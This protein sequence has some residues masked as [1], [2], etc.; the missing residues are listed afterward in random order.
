MDPHALAQAYG[1][2][3]YVY[4]AAAI[5]RNYHALTGALSLVGRPVAIHYAVK[6][7]YNLAV[8]HHLK[9][10]GAGAD[11][12]SGGE[13][14][15]A[16]AAGMAPSDI[17]FSGVAKT[18]A[19][20]R[21]ALAVGVGQINLESAEELDHLIHLCDALGQG[22]QCAV[23]I[24]PDV[25]TDT[26]AKISTGRAD[27]KFGVDIVTARRMFERARGT[28]VQLVGL[29][30]HIGSQLLSLAPYDQA[31]GVMARTAQDFAAAGHDIQVCDLGG[32]IG[33][34]YRPHEEPLDLAS[35]AALI[36]KHSAGFPGRLAMEPGRFLVANAG[37]LLV[38]VI[39]IK[40]TAHK[41]F[42][43]VDG[44]MND[45]MRPALYDAYHAITP[46]GT[47]SN[48][49]MTA[50]VVGGVCESSDVF[51]QGALL[52]ANLQSGD[53]L[54]IE[55]AGA[56][57]ATLS[58]TYNARD[59]AAEVWVDGISHQCIRR[60]WTAADHMALESIPDWRSA[61]ESDR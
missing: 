32:G 24:N 43:V 3:T 11:V 48:Q 42:V 40:R 18:D 45:L 17:V 61:A 39:F 55:N 38:R 27:H 36:Q 29:A 34:P 13:M 23:R 20:L 49:T 30:M 9:I 16:L 21:A 37:R 6:A 4:D 33:V 19:E 41:N 50:D 60:R 51:L 35:F 26:H 59:L 28:R 14:Q 53:L 7:N 46:A 31:F 22:V 12:V 25:E 57:G 44:A 8:L 56:Y 10:L 1:T 54:W 52:P 15:R 5:T 58:N 2:P 47:Q